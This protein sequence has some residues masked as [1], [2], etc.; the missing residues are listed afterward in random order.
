MKSTK[1]L[2]RDMIKKDRKSKNLL[3]FN[4][5]SM[6]SSP[7][8]GFKNVAAVFKDLV[9]PSSKPGGVVAQSIK[10]PTATGLGGAIVGGAIAQAIRPGAPIKVKVPTPVPTPTPRI[11]P[12]PSPLI[13][14][15]R[16]ITPAPKPEKRYWLP[17]PRG[18]LR[19]YQPTPRLA[20]IPDQT[21][22][23][24]ITPGT[25]LA[26]TA[27]SYTGGVIGETMRK[28]T[29]I[30]PEARLRPEVVRRP[31]TPPKQKIGRVTPINQPRRF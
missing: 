30:P 28:M 24:S 21:L 26:K 14:K 2:V 15:P 6:P 22:K 5:P 18:G 10:L 17:E 16:P 19:P 4:K 3:T 13:P 12:A 31:I 9:N 11:I 8:E 23:R 29:E 27:P 7:S 20:P 25:G 1:K